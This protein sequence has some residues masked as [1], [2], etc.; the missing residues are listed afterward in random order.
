MNV[1]MKIGRVMWRKE[2]ERERKG[3]HKAFKKK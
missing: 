1:Y 3:N 2:R